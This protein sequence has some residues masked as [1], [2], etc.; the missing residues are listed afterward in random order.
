M[1][2][3]TMYLDLKACI[4]ILSTCVLALVEEVMVRGSVKEKLDYQ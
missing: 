2:G 1:I 3:L 4:E